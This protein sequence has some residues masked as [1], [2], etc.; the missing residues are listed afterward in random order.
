[1]SYEK[2]TAPDMWKELGS[3]LK[4]EEEFVLGLSRQGFRNSDG[5]VYLDGVLDKA[6]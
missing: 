6:G 2:Y 4:T 5:S 1:M 3:H